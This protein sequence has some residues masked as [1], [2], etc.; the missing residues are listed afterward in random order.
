[1]GVLRFAE[2]EENSDEGTVSIDIRVMITVEI[3]SISDKMS[4]RY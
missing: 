3:L 4:V 1:M 2:P